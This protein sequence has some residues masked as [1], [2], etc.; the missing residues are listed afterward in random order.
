LS[1]S[2]ETCNIGMRSKTHV[3][4]VSVQSSHAH[5]HR[6]PVDNLENVD[7][8]EGGP[9]DWSWLNWLIVVI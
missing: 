2:N 4:F 8:E 5:L 9:Q 1:Q 3:L 7:D 6:M